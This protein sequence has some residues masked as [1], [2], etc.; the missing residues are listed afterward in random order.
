MAISYPGI[1]LL[2][3]DEGFYKLRW[4][5]DFHD[6]K[7]IRRG[8]WNVATR[9]HSD[10]AWAV[11]K[12]NLAQ[13]IIEVEHP[14]GLTLPALIVDGPDYVS[15]EW[16]VVVRAPMFLRNNTISALA[17]ERVLVDGLS[18]LT[19]T[20]KVQ[21]NHK[22]LIIPKPLSSHDKLFLLREHSV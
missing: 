21:V 3:N 18:I 17:L 4:R 8:V 15:L 6:H 19:R 14:N 11:P 9:N 20:H 13:A 22:G 5:F 10:S 2:E 7:P 12:D 1:P 16:D